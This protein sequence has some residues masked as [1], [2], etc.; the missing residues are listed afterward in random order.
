MDRFIDKVFVDFD[1]VEIF[2]NH[3]QA[4]LKETRLDTYYGELLFTTVLIA[5]PDYEFPDITPFYNTL[6]IFA[7]TAE[8]FEIFKPILPDIAFIK[9]RFIVTENT[10]LWQSAQDIDAKIVPSIFD[11]YVMEEINLSEPKIHE[12]D[13]LFGDSETIEDNDIVSYM[14]KK[15]I[16]YEKGTLKSGEKMRKTVLLQPIENEKLYKSLAQ[17]GLPV[18]S[19]GSKFVR[20]YHSEVVYV[21]EESDEELLM[22]NMSINMSKNVAQLKQNHTKDTKLQEAVA[23]RDFIIVKI[24]LEEDEFDVSEFIDKWQ[25]LLGKN[26]KLRE[27]WEAMSDAQFDYKLDNQCLLIYIA[28]DVQGMLEKAGFSQASRLINFFGSMLPKFGVKLDMKF[29]E[30]L[31]EYA[32]HA[33][34]TLWEWLKE[35]CI[36]GEAHLDF[37]QSIFDGLELIERL[38]ETA[39]IRD[40]FD[41]LKDS[42]D[43]QLTSLSFADTWMNWLF[44][45]L[46]LEED[47]ITAIN[48]VL[49]NIWGK[50]SSPEIEIGGIVGNLIGKLTVDDEH[51]LFGSDDNFIEL[52]ESLGT[53]APSPDDYAKDKFTLGK[54]SEGASSNDDPEKGKDMPSFSSPGEDQSIDITN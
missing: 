45:K 22:L 27:F 19:A 18:K 25:S 34:G 33:E 15:N 37:N 20:Q 29:G 35:N 28:V 3:K 6:F 31:A 42:L 17:A 36:S 47:S 12:L 53:Y 51:F 11:D 38:V 26:E 32:E 24:G 54:D 43:S 44:S 7:E 23:T 30:T 16:P 39:E 48:K 52:M 21:G 8:D 5:S 41:Q 10:S 13:Q 40:M 2:D 46:N 14:S 49:K 50:F 1:P 4:D 9:Q